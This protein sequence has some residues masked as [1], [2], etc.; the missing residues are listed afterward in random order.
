[1][2]E[3]MNDNGCVV[4]VATYNT[5]ITYLCKNGNFEDAFGILDT[6][7]CIFGEQDIVSCNI[8]VS[9]LY[10]EGKIKEAYDIFENMPSRGCEPT[11]VTYRIMLDGLCGARCFKEASVFLESMVPKGFNPRRISV[12]EVISDLYMDGKIDCALS[13]LRN[14]EKEC[15]VDF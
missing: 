11:M 3:E 8:I 15:L 1:M 7:K 13:L 6:M 5:F 10:R 2:L 12:Y 9:G 14:M 4:H